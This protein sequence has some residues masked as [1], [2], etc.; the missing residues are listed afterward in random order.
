MVEAQRGDGN[1][2]TRNRAAEISRRPGHIAVSSEPREDVS[3][4]SVWKWGTTAMFDIIIVNLNVGS[5]LR[6]TPKKNLAKAEKDK[7]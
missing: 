1:R 4:H 3:L 7:K 6:M 5:Y 2:Q